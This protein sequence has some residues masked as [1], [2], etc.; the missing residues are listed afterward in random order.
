MK[1]EISYRKFQKEDAQAIQNI[2]VEAWHYNDLCSNKTAHKMAKVFLSSCLTNQTY[3]QVALLDNKPIGV[4]MAKNRN[5]HTC[6]FKY[7]IR[8]I[9]AIT[10]LYLSKEGRKVSKIFSNVSEIDKELIEKSQKQY[11]GEVA[12]F[13]VSSSAR[14]KGL[15][16]KMFCDM[17]EYM[18]SQDINSFYLF[19]DTSCNYGFYEHQGMTRRNEKSHSFWIQGKEAKMTFFIYDYFI[20]SQNNR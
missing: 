4:M 7:R 6:P 19:T 20:H 13:A 2:I 10:S 16:K 18:K 3:T 11:Q 12:F 14:G 1:T 17:L 5:T 9:F 8:Q 15:G